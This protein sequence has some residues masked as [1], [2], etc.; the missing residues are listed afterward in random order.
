MAGACAT[1]L[2]GLA[3]ACLGGILAVTVVY[4]YQYLPRAVPYSQLTVTL[5]RG[6]YAGIRTTPVRAAYLEQLTR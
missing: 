4:Q 3:L 6:P 5:H 2:P 1:A